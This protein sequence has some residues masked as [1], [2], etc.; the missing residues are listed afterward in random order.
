MLT[1]IT[2]LVYCVALAEIKTRNWL[3]V[4]MKVGYLVGY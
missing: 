4:F 3:A 1:A 2:P